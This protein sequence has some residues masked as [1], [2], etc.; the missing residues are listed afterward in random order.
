MCILFLRFERVLEDKQYGAV[1]WWLKNE[2]NLRGRARIRQSVVKIFV[3]WCK[4][5]A[6]VSV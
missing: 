4:E 6:C 2:K 1:V 3:S 5:Y